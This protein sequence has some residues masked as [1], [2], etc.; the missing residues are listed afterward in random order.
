MRQL[1]LIQN[2]KDKY[3]QIKQGIINAY[4]DPEL[5][6]KQLFPLIA[7]ISTIV[8]WVALIIKLM[9]KPTFP[10][11]NDIPLLHYM[12][13]QILEGQVPYKD[14]YDHNLPGAYLI[15]LIALIFFGKSDEAWTIFTFI[16]MA[17]TA[18][19]VGIYCWRISRLSAFLTPALI[20]CST[21]FMDTFSF[22]QRDQLIVLFLILA[23]HLFANVLE[24]PDITPPYSKA[25]QLF[26]CGLALS[27]ATFIKPTPIVL[28]GLFFIILFVKDFRNYRSNMLGSSLLDKRTTIKH[29]LIQYFSLALGSILPPLIF[30]FWL[31]LTGALLPFLEIMQKFNGVIYSSIERVELPVL[32]RLMMAEFWPLSV[33]LIFIVIGLFAIR[34]SKYLTR[35]MIALLLLVFGAF[36]YI[37]QGKGW[38]HHLVPFS[39]FVLILQGIFCGMLFKKG[40]VFN[41]MGMVWLLLT[42]SIYIIQMNIYVVIPEKVLLDRKPAVP[43]LVQ[44]LNDL[45]ISEED[46]IQVMD[47]AEGGL[48]VLFLL[49][50]RQATPYLYDFTLID[51]AD[52]LYMKELQDDFIDR[53][54]LDPPKWIVFFNNGG[55]PKTTGISRLNADP[56]LLTFLNS[57]YHSVKVREFYTIYEHNP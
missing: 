55:L 1:L 13:Q 14:F 46:R 51:A 49:Q 43:L 34:E 22:G 30:G 17:Y 19:I 50:H 45:G 9:G 57:D 27:F 32:F 7:A 3:L 54:V 39:I 40:L 28:L 18:V 31:S 53:L 42:V 26:A 16:W 35:I 6:K 20:A 12:S 48:H 15:H 2:S 33:N 24:N 25:K 47:R 37:L 8:L 23:S 11:I 44:D 29:F 21:L 4:S 5:A 10:I 38:D 41:V 56:R 52:D 36:H